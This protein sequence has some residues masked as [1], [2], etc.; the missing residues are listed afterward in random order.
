MRR[1]DEG[2]IMLSNSEKFLI[3]HLCFMVILCVMIITAFATAPL[4]ID[5][6]F[7]LL[8]KEEEVTVLA[9]EQLD[10]GLQLVIERADGTTSQVKLRNEL[11]DYILFEVGQK[12][13]VKIL[14]GS[15]EYVKAVTTT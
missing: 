7:K 8:A 15:C 11:K 1:D 2:K 10:S 6:T 14:N 3:S 13:I 9:K 4:I 12:Y 5:S